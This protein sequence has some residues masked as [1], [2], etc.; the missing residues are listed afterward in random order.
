MFFYDGRLSS[1]VSRLPVRIRML[2]NPNI[3]LCSCIMGLD[4]WVRASVD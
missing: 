1:A 2:C 4:L 3:E